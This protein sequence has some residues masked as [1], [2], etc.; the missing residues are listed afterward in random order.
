MKTKYF[1][2]QS[3]FHSDEYIQSEW[4][5]HSYSDTFDGA[6]RD[7]ELM[8]GINYPYVDYRIV[9]STGKEYMV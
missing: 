2:T 4:V 1:I 3:R 5:S 8:K 7:V 6:R 9:D